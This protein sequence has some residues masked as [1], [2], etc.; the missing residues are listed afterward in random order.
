MLLSSAESPAAA[1]M[2]E[3]KGGGSHAPVYWC[4]LAGGFGTAYFCQ[5]FVTVCSA[6]GGKTSTVAIETVTSVEVSE[7][8]GMREGERSACS[9]RI[10]PGARGAA[11]IEATISMSNDAKDTPPTSRR[12]KRQQRLKRSSPTPF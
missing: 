8:R 5:E 1:K 4:R 7:R 3:A 10:P 9:L 11:R 2:K 12:A 6:G